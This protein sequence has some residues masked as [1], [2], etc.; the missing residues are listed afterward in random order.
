MMRT[1]ALLVAACAVVA[2]AAGAADPPPY[3]N[4]VIRMIT[5]EVGGASDLASR[6]M[7]QALEFGL[8]FFIGHGD[9]LW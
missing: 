8:H 4:R 6:I 3:P 7:T 9:Y 5:P 1:D 2:S